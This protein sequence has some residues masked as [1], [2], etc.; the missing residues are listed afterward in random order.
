MIRAN[1]IPPTQTRLLMPLHPLPCPFCGSPKS[2][3]LEVDVEGWAV[4]CDPCG[5]IGPI[6]SAESEATDA[7]NARVA[8]EK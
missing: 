1:G 6:K 7:W 8:T 4:I 3:L 5:T 2:S